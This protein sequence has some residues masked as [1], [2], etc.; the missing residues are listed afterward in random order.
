MNDSFLTSD[1]R[2]ESFMTTGHQPPISLLTP[3]GPS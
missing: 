3:L 1:A 2:K